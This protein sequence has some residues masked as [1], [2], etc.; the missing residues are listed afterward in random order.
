VVAARLAEVLHRGARLVFDPDPEHP[1]I[2]C[3]SLEAQ[4]AA[5]PL[6]DPAVKPAARALLRHVS[7]YRRILLDLFRLNGWSAPTRAEALASDRAE[8]RRLVDEEMRLVDELGPDLADAVRD[9]IAEDYRGVTGLC[10]LCGDADHA[11]W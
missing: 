8:A 11:G 1:T 3:P 9:Q 2:R 5:A 6:A 10:P 7:T 4:H